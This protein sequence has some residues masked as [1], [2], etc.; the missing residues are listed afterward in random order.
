MLFQKLLDNIATAKGAIGHKKT[1]LKKALSYLTL[2]PLL[3]CLE[4]SLDFEQGGDISSNLASLYLFCS[5]QLLEAST[6]ND[7]EKLK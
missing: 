3:V 1:T 7:I 6:S 5:E 4:G 2:L